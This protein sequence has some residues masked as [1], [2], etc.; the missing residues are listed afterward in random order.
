[1][2]VINVSNNYDGS[3]PAYATAM[4]TLISEG[5][6]YD[7]MVPCIAVGTVSAADA[8]YVL[9]AAH[10][11]VY[12]KVMVSPIVNVTAAQAR[13][14][15]GLL[16]SDDTQYAI[17]YN[18]ATY[19]SA[20]IAGAAAGRISK[21]SPWISPSWGSVSGINASGYSPDDVTTLEGTAASIAINTII[22]VGGVVGLSSGRSLKA[23]TWLDRMRTEQFATDRIRDDLLIDKQR[24]AN[25]NQKIEYSPQGI[26]ETKG[27]IESSCRYIQSVRAIKQ[28]DPDND[29]VGFLVTMPVFADISEAN[30]SNRHL[31]DVSV[32]LYLSDSYE[33]IAIQLT[34][35]L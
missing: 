27:I 18:D 26:G 17:A 34:L 11:L 19:T 20:E 22:S 10:A 9:M 14:A 33:T 32:I 23:G 25:S 35:T 4:T 21:Q 2:R 29:I 30:K 1:V 28:D 3:T 12:R 13:T 31:P 15:M 7:I 16:T 24:K 8:D 5:T 6:D